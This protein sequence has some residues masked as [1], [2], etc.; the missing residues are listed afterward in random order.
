MAQRFLPSLA[1]SSTSMCTCMKV[2]ARSRNVYALPFSQTI[3]S[4]S[5]V[6]G[7][8][9]NL[10]TLAEARAGKSAVRQ[11]PAREHRDLLPADQLLGDAHGIPGRGVV[12][13]AHDL[14]LSP[15]DPTCGVDLLD[16]QL[17]SLL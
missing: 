3:L 6:C 15:A 12:I 11:N 17:P 4:V 10:W 16:G 7:A 1:A 5:G 13:A 14:D 9:K 8:D 2:D